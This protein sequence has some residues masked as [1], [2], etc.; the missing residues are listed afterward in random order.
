MIAA[1]RAA[2][3]VRQLATD[4]GSSG[5]RRVLAVALAG[6]S[7]AGCAYN[8]DTGRSPGQAFAEAGVIGLV[9]DS[10]AP[11]RVGTPVYGKAPDGTPIV[12]AV[13]P[14]VPRCDHAWP[15]WLQH[16]CTW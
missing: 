3:G 9:D 12:V 16:G 8:P 7:L 14:P 15:I 6:L 1:C 5:V 11:H 4:A 10:L 2:R 13:I